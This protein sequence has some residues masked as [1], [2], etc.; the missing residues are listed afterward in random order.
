MT[1]EFQPSFDIG[2]RSVGGDA[3]CLVIAEAAAAGLPV[4]AADIPGIH[5]AAKAC[6]SAKLL[7]VDA[8]A[9]AWAGAVLDGLNHPPLSLSERRSMLEH[10]PFTI[11]AS[12]RSLNQLYGVD[13]S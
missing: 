13:Q 1:P 4:V 10:F 5:D 7:P 8:T 2:G 6:H 12:I 9:D 3:P 11:E